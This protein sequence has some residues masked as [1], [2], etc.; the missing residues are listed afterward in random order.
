[1]ATPHVEPQLVHCIDA[2]PTALLLSWG[3]VP[4]ALKYELE[5]R[6][7]GSDEWQKLGQAGFTSGMPPKLK[8]NLAPGT[9]YE[10]RMR[11]RDG[12]DWMPWSEISEHRTITEDTHRM[13]APRM[14]ASDA[15]SIT[16]EWSAVKGAVAYEIQMRESRDPAWHTIAP[17]F[18]SN[19]MGGASLLY[20]RASRVFS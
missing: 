4:K 14:A 1:M 16:I 18:A 15:H 5:F 9:V 19:V 10:F 11:A 3:N 8:K 12:V 7:M 17:S 2:A 13:D 20:S 6:P